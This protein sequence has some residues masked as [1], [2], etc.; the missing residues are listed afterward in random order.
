MICLDEATLIQF[1]VIIIKHAPD[2]TVLVFGSRIKGTHK[3]YS[4][5]DLAFKLTDNAKLGFSRIAK[6]KEAFEESNIPIK[7]D[8]IDYNAASAEFRRIIDSGYVVIF[9]GDKDN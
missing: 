7:V 5:L 2:C 8:V 1:K 6:I 4:D 9:E 3:K